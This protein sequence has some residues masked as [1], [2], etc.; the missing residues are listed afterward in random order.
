MSYGLKLNK[1]LKDGVKVKANITKIVSLP[2]VGYLHAKIIRFSVD[3][4][5][6]KYR[7][8]EIRN[9]EEGVNTG[10]VNC[11]LKESDDNSVVILSYFSFPSYYFYDKG[12]IS[13]NFVAVTT[14]LIFPI[15]C[16]YMFFA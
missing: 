15:V 14:R 5:G 8:L 7:G 6:K 16:F 13:V 10:V 9:V 4:K 2:G 12:V 11:L 3:Y 1:C